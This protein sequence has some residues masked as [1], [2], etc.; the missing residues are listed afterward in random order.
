LAG[1]GA[2]EFVAILT[3]LAKLEDC[4]SLLE[5]LLSAISEPMIIDDTILNLL[6]SVG[7]TFYPQ[8]NVNAGQFI[9]HVFC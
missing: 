8:D 4:E 1:F 2:D 7:V 3:N 5:S 9:R 6:A